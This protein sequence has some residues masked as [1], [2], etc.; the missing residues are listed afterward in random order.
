MAKAMGGHRGGGNVAH[1]GHGEGDA[2]K[3]RA[4]ATRSQ[5]L[6]RLRRRGGGGVL[7]RRRRT[8]GGGIVVVGAA[9]YELEHKSV[10]VERQG[11]GAHQPGK[12]APA[13]PGAGAPSHDRE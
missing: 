5:G 9:V 12:G 1:R 4:A 7:C 13:H 3:P 8:V 10:D 11:E 6:A 2:E